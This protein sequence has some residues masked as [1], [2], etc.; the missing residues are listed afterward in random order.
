MTRR[1]RPCLDCG[2]PTRNGSRCTEHAT[3]YG[4]TS[5]HW[6]QVR[7]SRLAFDGHRCQLRHPGCTGR[8]TS[9]HLDPACNGDHAL[10]S[11]QNTT[12]AHK[13][14]PT[15]GGGVER[16]QGESLYPCTLLAMCTAPHNAEEV[17]RGAAA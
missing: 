15:P 12:S 1:L 16:V 10:A 7:A 13:P 11:I 6:Q 4:Y 8:A 9:V 2:R 5:S 3:S 14:H 17:P